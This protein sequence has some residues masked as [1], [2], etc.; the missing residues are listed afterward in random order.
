MRQLRQGLVDE[1]VPKATW[2]HELIPHFTEAK[3]GLQK[4]FPSM[5]R[6]GEVNSGTNRACISTSVERTLWGATSRSP[7]EAMPSCRP[8]CR[9]QALHQPASCNAS[10]TNEHLKAYHGLAL[11]GPRGREKNRR[12]A[13]H[14]FSEEVTSLASGVVGV[15]II[16]LSRSMGATT[17][18]LEVI[19]LHQM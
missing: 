7:L 1:T 13:P 19:D 18:D 8:G 5:K 9:F 12:S 6:R 2:R 14:A 10:T 15:C 17:P 11:G 3:S 16:P 4:T